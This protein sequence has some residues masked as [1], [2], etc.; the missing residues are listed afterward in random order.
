MGHRPF[1]QL[2]VTANLVPNNSHKHI[3]DI[4]IQGESTGA[5]QSRLLDVGILPDTAKMHALGAQTCQVDVQVHTK[6]MYNNTISP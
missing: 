2:I 1:V 3:F 6:N 4:T 5:N